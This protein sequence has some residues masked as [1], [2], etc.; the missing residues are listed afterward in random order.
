MRNV[1]VLLLLLAASGCGVT[2]DD[3]PVSFAYI[4]TAILQPSCGTAACHSAQNRA[5]ALILDTP[6]DAYRTLLD[7]NRLGACA[8]SGCEGEPE[9]SSLYVVITSD[10]NEGTPRMPLD[11]PLPDADI[12]LIAR[13]LTAGAENN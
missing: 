13:W 4:T 12:A 8:S 11:A 5:E 6:Q 7:D 3:R 9:Q 1:A 2:T 10:T